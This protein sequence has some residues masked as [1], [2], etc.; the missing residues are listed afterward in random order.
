MFAL[1]KRCC[2]VQLAAEANPLSR[3]LTT[4]PVGKKGPESIQFARAEIDQL[5]T[6]R[7]TQMLKVAAMETLSTRTVR[8]SNDFQIKHQV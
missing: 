4:E 5:N 8:I 1:D 3:S 7:R 6:A 2:I